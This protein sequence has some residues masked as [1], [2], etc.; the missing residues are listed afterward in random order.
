MILTAIIHDITIT[1]FILV[2]KFILT[3]FIFFMFSPVNYMKTWLKKYQSTYWTGM[4]D[5]KF[6]I[7]QYIEHSNQIPYFQS[8]PNIFCQIYQNT[9]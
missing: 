6:H 8:K 9:H 2:S 3:I 5:I 7:Y 1:T 4:C